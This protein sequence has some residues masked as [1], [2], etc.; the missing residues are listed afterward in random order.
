MIANGNSFSNTGQLANG[1]SSGLQDPES[2]ERLGGPLMWGWNGF[3]KAG[4]AL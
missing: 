2:T 4:N 3:Q 1:N